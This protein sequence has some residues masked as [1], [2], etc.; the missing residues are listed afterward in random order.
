MTIV[1]C[2]NETNSGAIR[3]LLQTQNKVALNIIATK[4]LSERNFSFLHEKNSKVF[5]CSLGGNYGFLE[6]VELSDCYT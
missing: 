4:T 3:F 5:S 6:L 2:K 1:I